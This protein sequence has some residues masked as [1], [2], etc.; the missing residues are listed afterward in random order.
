M[1]PITV[2]C[3]AAMAIALLAEPPAQAQSR[4]ALPAA[5]PA[6]AAKWIDAWAVSF[7]PTT[8]NGTRQSSRTFES[9]TLRLN[10]FAKLGGTQAR[11]KFTNRFTAGAAPAQWDCRRSG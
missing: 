6:A 5:A 3:V 1:R 8:V 10:V 2:C 9:Q 4:G 11:V 7:I